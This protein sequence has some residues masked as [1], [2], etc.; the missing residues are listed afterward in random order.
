MTFEV[1]GEILFSPWFLLLALLLG[2]FFFINML[3]LTEYKRPRKFDTKNF[4][5]SI[6]PVY[7]FSPSSIDQGRPLY[8]SVMHAEGWTSYEVPVNQLSTLL[9][10]FDDCIAFGKNYSGPL[11]LGTMTRGTDPLMQT[12]ISYALKQEGVFMPWLF[13]LHADARDGMVTISMNEMNGGD[14]I[15]LDHF[16]RW[17]F[18]LKEFLV[19]NGHP[20][21][22]SIARNES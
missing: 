12:S 7:S 8:F 16:E 3:A 22:T 19:K 13:K 14:H 20:P 4:S 9:K 5:A 15:P 2:L 1:I 21:E 10:I 17:V 6:L 18:K 11:H